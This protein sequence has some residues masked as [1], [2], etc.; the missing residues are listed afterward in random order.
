MRTPRST[1]SL[2]LNGA[3]RGF[4]EAEADGIV[5]V[6]EGGARYLAGGADVAAGARALAAMA[7]ELAERLDVRVALHTDHYAYETGLATPGA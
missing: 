3:P 7:R 6:T 5:Q 4:A 2:A 1:S